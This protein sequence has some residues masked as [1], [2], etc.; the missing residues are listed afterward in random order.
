MTPYDLKRDAMAAQAVRLSM[1]HTEI[2]GLKRFLKKL[3]EEGMTEENRKRIEVIT[4]R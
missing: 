1:A 3:L 2:K 4:R